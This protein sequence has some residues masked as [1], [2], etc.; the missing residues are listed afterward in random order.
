MDVFEFPWLRFRVDGPSSGVDFLS[1]FSYSW[2][3][4]GKL[5]FRYRHRLKQENLSLPD[6]AENLL[7]DVKRD[8]LRIDFQFKLND[9]WSIK[10]RADATLFEKE[11]SS[12][13]KGI[14]VYQDVFWQGLANKLRLN[15][16]LAYFNTDDYDSR[17]YAYESD[18]LYASSFPMYYDK[19]IRSY[20]NF[21]WR[22]SRKL[23]LWGRYAL[24]AYQDREN[25]GSALDLI[26][27]NKKSDVKFQLR[28]QW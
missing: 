28:W 18:V 22:I 11:L 13:S 23:D 26:E 9:T 5:T 3:K 27:G 6:K 10:T 17:L 16:R 12:T 24:T 1:Q 21:R 4:K 20:F 15:M 2:H 19:G 25:V 14:L 8:Q 7:A